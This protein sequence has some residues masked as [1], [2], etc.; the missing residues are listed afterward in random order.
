MKIDY[1]CDKCGEFQTNE[2][3]ESFICSCGGQMRLATELAMTSRPFDAGWD[4]TLKCEVTSWKDQEKK[5]AAYRSKAHPMGF[6]MLNDNKKFLNELKNI[7][8]YKGDY[9]KATL[10]GFKTK[11]MEKAYD[12]N[13]PDSH[14]TG[15]RIYSHSK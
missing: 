13:R 8:K 2:T 5:A 7:R 9:L 10:P 14:N 4:D 6:Q 12:K 3:M 15:R 11:H 1:S